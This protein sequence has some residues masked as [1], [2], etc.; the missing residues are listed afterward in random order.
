MWIVLLQLKKSE[1]HLSEQWFHVV[2][3]KTD[4]GVRDVPIADKIV[5]LFENLMKTDGEYFIANKKSLYSYSVFKN[6]FWI[7][8]NEELGTNHLP[9]DTRHTCVSRLAEAKIEQTT[10]KKIVG[11]VGAMS[12]TEKVYTHYDIKPLLEAVNL[13]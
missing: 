5:P 1:V 8:L 9:H 6:K 7:P 11:H 10:I 3:A 4:A 12:V 2:K 13:I